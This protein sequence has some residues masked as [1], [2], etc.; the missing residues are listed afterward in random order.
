MMMIHIVSPLIWHILARCT[1]VK[2]SY[3]TSYEI[4]CIL[5]DT[6]YSTP[7]FT[8]GDTVISVQESSATGHFKLYSITTIATVID[9]QLFGVLFTDVQLMA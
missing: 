2:L 9:C 8:D 5:C 6:I 7:R 1:N 3:C 4:L